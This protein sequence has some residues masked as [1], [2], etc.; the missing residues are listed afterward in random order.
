MHFKH[1][2]N[3]EELSRALAPIFNA[4]M[5]ELVAAG[6]KYLQFEDLVPLCAGADRW[7]FLCVVAALRIPG[8][9]GSPINPIAVV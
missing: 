6:A 8:G 3:N 2:K 7:S 1:Y 5:K 9:T 4:E